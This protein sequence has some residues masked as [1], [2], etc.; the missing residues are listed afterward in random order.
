[1]TQATISITSVKT[2]VRKP[3][4][5][6]YNEQWVSLRQSLVWT[7]TAQPEAV[8]CLTLGKWASRQVLGRGTRSI[9]SPPSSVSAV[10]EGGINDHYYNDYKLS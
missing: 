4:R 10:L 7:P 2:Q 1:M 6:T 8:L 5:I 9:T 3:K